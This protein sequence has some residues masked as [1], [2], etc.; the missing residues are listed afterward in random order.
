M[1]LL[2]KKRDGVG[3]YLI[4]SGSYILWYGIAAN[5]PAGFS[6]DTT[7]YDVF[8]RGASQGQ[9]SD[10]IA[11]A[12]SHT[13]TNPAS[14]DSALD[15]AHTIGGGS[16]GNSS[17]TT[18]VFDTSGQNLAKAHN[19]TIGTTS[20]SSNAAHNHTISAPESVTIYPSYA[21]LYWIK[22]NTD[23]EFPIGGIVMWDNLSNNRPEGTQLCNG[24]NGTPNLIDKFIY[25]AAADGDVGAT[26]GSDLHTHVNSGTSSNG[27]HTHQASP[28]IGGAASSNDASGSAGV[29]VAAGGHSHS[30]DL[31]TS[32]SGNHSHTI[33]NTQ[34]EYHLP[35]YLLLYFIMRTV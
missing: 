1:I 9:A 25:G 32:A 14:V 18:V 23:C 19:H 3:G 2:Q 26:G 17:G 7:A 21:K 13:H 30:V 31:T 27:D 11:G 10:T 33:G 16:T 28:S 35:S 6:I 20:S 34:S 15:H 29:Y 24:S 8:V 4:P 5:V 22:A 12:L